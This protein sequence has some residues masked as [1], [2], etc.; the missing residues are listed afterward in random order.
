MAKLFKKDYNNMLEKIIEKKQYNEN[1]KSLLLSMMYKIEVA[2]D[3]Y[4][5]V[6]QDTESKDEFITNILEIIRKECKKIQIVKRNTDIE[7]ELKDENKEFIIDFQKGEII[8]YQIEKCLL[9]AIFEI[10]KPQMYVDEENYLI[11]NSIIYNLIKGSNLDKVEILKDFNGWSWNTVVEDENN[12][13]P[14]LIYKLIWIVM[15]NENLQKLLNSKD[16]DIIQIL[17]SET[18]KKCK[19]ENSQKFLWSIYKFSIN[20]FSNINKK[21]KGVLLEEKVSIE[22]EFN[23]LSDKIKYVK[24]ITKKFLKLMR[25]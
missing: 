8:T 1:V 22:N 16:M 24:D 18:R 13:A 2:Y 6:K 15:G 21:E 7:K 3:D 17:E 12:I 23:L 10:N 11:R 25:L 19:N 5:T 4:K 20:S 14:N 9:Y